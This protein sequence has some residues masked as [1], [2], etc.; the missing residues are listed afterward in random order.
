MPRR[1]GGVFRDHTVKFDE[2]VLLPL[3]TIIF[4]GKPSQLST[5]IPLCSGNR[6]NYTR[7][8]LTLGYVV[9]LV[10]SSV[11]KYIHHG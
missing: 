6:A 5:G 8:S 10:A 11:S 9:Y 4:A 2:A 3:G 7:N 1:S